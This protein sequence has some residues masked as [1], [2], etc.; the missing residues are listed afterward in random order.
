MS[1]ARSEIEK[2]NFERDSAVQLLQEAKAARSEFT[3]ANEERDNAL[4]QLQAFQASGNTAGQ[5]LLRYKTSNYKSYIKSKSLCS[6]AFPAQGVSGTLN[7]QPTNGTGSLTNTY[8]AQHGV[9]AFPEKY[10]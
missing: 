8:P 3:R 1:V 10:K 6:N 4:K 5:N 2:A 9:E 7:F